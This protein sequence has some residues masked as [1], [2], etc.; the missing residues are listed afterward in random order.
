[1]RLRSAADNTD[2]PFGQ[3]FDELMQTRRQEFQQYQ[4]HVLGLCDPEHANIAGQA[5]A[6]LL[7][8]KQY[9]GYVVREWL[10]GDPDQPPRSATSSRSRTTSISPPSVSGTNHSNRDTSKFSDVENSTRRSRSAP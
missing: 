2:D 5:I 10:S 4:S 6:G 9:Y 1:M 3:R 7:W 8:S